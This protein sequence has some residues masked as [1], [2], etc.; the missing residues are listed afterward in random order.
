MVSVCDKDVTVA[1]ATYVCIFTNRHVG[2]HTYATAGN[3][4]LRMYTHISLCPQ[5]QLTKHISIYVSI[6]E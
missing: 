4:H 5:Q 2:M 6:G 3:M 1:L